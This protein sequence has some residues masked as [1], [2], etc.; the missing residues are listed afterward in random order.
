MVRLGLGKNMVRSVRFWVQVFGIARSTSRSGR[1]LTPTDFGKRV[2]CPTK[3]RDPF[4]ED[5]QTL[6]LLHWNLAD[7]AN[8]LL[9]WQELLFR[10]PSP[11]FTRTEAVTELMNRA[12]QRKM[13]GSRRTLE[14]HF[15][16][17]LR[18]Y[19]SLRPK[20]NEVLEDSLDCPLTELGLIQAAGEKRQ[21]SG[22]TEPIYALRLE[23]KPAI[24]SAL[25]VYVLTSFWERQHSDEQTLSLQQIVSGEGSPGRVLRLPEADIRERLGHIERDSDGLFTFV[26]SVNLQQVQRSETTSSALN[27]LG[28]VYEESHAHG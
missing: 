28:S 4:L 23:P 11:E 24:G 12:V 25:F 16:I 13:R 5:V 2:L 26:E 14:Q 20:K 3:G 21:I 22:I 18:T 10:W 27:L 8:E 15:D 19:V 1:D 6:W 17:F 7:P 9:T